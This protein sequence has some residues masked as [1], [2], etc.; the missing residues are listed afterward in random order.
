MC[1]CIWALHWGHV[2]SVVAVVFQFARRERVLERDVFRFGTATSVPLLFDGALGG[3]AGVGRT[4]RS[5]RPTGGRS[6]RAG[7][8]GRRPGALHTRSTD[9]DSP[10]GTPA[11]TAVQAPPCPGARARGRTGRPRACAPRSRRRPPPPRGGGQH[12][13]R[14]RTAPGSD[15]P[16]RGRPG[17]GTARRRRLPWR[18]PSRSPALPRP[19]TRAAAR[20][21]I[22]AP[23]GHRDDVRAEVGRRLDGPLDPHHGSGSPTE[24]RGVED[25]RRSGIEVFHGS[26]C[27]E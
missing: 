16:R 23:C 6:H 26:S 27:V 9:P 5:A 25:Q 13:R 1:G 15:R 21:R 19:R 14:R 8:R 2:V 4:A 10:P 17:P 24:V 3:G 11:G 22:S 18:G 7:G 12:G 20:S